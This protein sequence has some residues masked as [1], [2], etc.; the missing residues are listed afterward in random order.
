MAPRYDRNHHPFWL[1][2]HLFQI[3]LDEKQ[4]IFLHKLRKRWLRLPI[5]RGKLSRSPAFGPRLLHNPVVMI[6]L[7]VLFICLL[8]F[9]EGLFNTRQ[10]TAMMTGVDINRLDPQ[11]A[12]PD[13]PLP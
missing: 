3:W 8:V 12:T 7:L 4:Y 1:R 13:N 5:N 2:L 6:V 9:G 10:I 11:G